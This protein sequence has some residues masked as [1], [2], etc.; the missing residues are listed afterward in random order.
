MKFGHRLLL[1]IVLGS[2]ATGAIAACVGDEPVV[3]ATDGDPDATSSSDGGSTE[4]EA[5]TQTEG[6]GDASKDT[7]KD[8]STPPGDTG[9]ADAQTGCAA[10][11]VNDTTGVFVASS[12]ND[13]SGCG[14]R[15]NPCKTLTYTFAGGAQLSGKTVAYVASGTYNESIQLIAG[16]SVE[17][18]WMATGSIWSPICDATTSTAVTLHGTTN[19]TITASYNGT[20][21]LRNVQVTSKA[22]VGAGESVYGIFATGGSTNLT[23]DQVVVAVAAGGAGANGADGGAA[24]NASGTCSAGNGAAGSTGPNGQG[25]VAGSFDPSGYTASNGAAATN[26]TAGANGTAGGSGSCATCQTFA[27]SCPNSCGFGSAT[28]CGAT[29]TSGCGGGPGGGGAGGHGGGSSVAVYV[30]GAHVTTFGGNLSSGNGG[31]GG[32]GGE[33]ASGGTPSAGAAG[34]AKSCPT[35][36]SNPSCFLSQCSGTL[37]SETTLNGGSAGG[38]GGTGGAGGHGG[39]GAGGFSYAIYV[40]ADGGATLNGGTT[41]AHGDAGAGGA[42]NGV[43]GQA[44]DRFP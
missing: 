20:T 32:N 37:V 13:V 38:S 44:A 26:A 18:G 30:W 15:S 24:T 8:T 2:A 21:T 16:L 22:S 1:G 33:G 36:L 5:T 10:R 23:L 9:T 43:P 6:G 39:G 27:G 17:G 42:V 12:G 25:A 40:G 19:T 28:L 29:G 11:T 3:S 31:Y 4:H 34:A 7:S 14:S 35:Q 41:L